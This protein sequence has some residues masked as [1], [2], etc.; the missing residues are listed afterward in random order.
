MPCMQKSNKLKFGKYTAF[1]Y[2][3]FIVI[4]VYFIKIQLYNF[5][6]QNPTR[7]CKVSMSVSLVLSTC[8]EDSS[9]EINYYHL[10]KTVH[11]VIHCYLLKTTVVKLSIAFY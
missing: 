5:F 7:I 11:W 6:S 4:A 3:L 10:L 1:V 8:T 2:G 9:N